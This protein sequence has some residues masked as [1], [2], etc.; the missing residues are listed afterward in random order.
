MSFAGRMSPAKRELLFRLSPA[1][2]ATHGQYALQRE[3]LGFH[4]NIIQHRRLEKCSILTVRDFNE[5]KTGMLL[6]PSVSSR[7]RADEGVS[8]TATAYA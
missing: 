2:R 8:H 7:D 1:H 5:P 3:F 4:N 6:R